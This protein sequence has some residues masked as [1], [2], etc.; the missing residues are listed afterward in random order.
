M[1]MDLL[2]ST[3][4]ARRSCRG[5]VGVG[6]RALIALVMTAGEANFACEHLAVNFGDLRV[7]EPSHRQE[8]VQLQWH[9][10]VGE[11]HD[12][13]NRKEV[14]ASKS[15]NGC[16]L[17]QFRRSQSYSSRDDVCCVVSNR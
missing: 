6:G 14:F 8:Y 11:V 15:R 7:C 1:P 10:C 9:R 16:K 4:E 3:I 2:P 5:I 17:E 12:I 13:K